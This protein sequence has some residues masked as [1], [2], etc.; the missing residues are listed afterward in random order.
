M[1]VSQAANKHSSW[2]LSNQ[3]RTA[4]LKSGLLRPDVAR[5][6]SAAED[7]TGAARSGQVEAATQTGEEVYKFGSRAGRLLGTTI[8]LAIVIAPGIIFHTGG[9]ILFGIWLAPIC[10]FLAVKLLDDPY[11]IRIWRSGE[12]NFTSITRTVVIHASDIVRFVR[13]ERLSTHGLHWVG[14]VHGSGTV[15]LS[16]REEVLARL[17]ALR[18]SAQVITKVIDD[19]D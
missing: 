3:L 17:T 14:V 11:E 6:A 16:G 8:A 4:F 13:H 15:T 1:K 9:A 19:T 7:Q 10:L 2:D 18:P 5:T 12:I